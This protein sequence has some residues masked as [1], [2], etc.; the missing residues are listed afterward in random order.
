MKPTSNDVHVDAVLSNISIAYMN[1]VEDFVADRAFP[2]VPVEH[3]SDLFFTYEK[4]A[5]LRDDMQKRA[6]GGTFPLTDYAVSTDTY[7]CIQ[8]ALGTDVADEVPNNADSPINLDTE[9]TQLL[10]HRALMRRERLFSVAYMTTGVWA[11]DN[12]SA[13][14]WDATSTPITDIQVAKRTIKNA[15]GKTANILVMGKIVHDA[16]LTNAQIVDLIKYEARAL[17]PDINAALATALGLKLILVSDVV[18]E[19]ADEGETSSLSPVMDDDALL[20]HVPDAPGIL[21]PSAGYTFR[22]DGGGGMGQISRVRDDMNDRDVL[23]I[24]MSIDQNLVASDLGYFF[25]DI[26]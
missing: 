15:S 25:S 24:K 14:D 2:F 12:T 16:L 5:F 18:Y 7:S 22:W 3:Q 23:K 20:L 21:T 9:K 8:W 6:P 10:A 11:T 13:T 17:P 26:V 19:T 4:G 1:N